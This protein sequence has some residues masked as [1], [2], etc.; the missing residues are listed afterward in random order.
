MRYAWPAQL[1]LA[2][3][4][5]IEGPTLTRHL[6]GLE[7]AGLVVRRRAPSDRRAVHV[8]LTDDG[9]RKH[10][11]LREA[12]I[13]FDRRLRAGLGEPEVEQ[14]RELLQ[15]LE[16]NVRKSDGAAGGG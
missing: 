11:E 16:G 13:A 8:E 15:R 9:R 5:R 10:A 4:L 14:L 2:R 1:E 7:Q 3:E 12:V 6:D